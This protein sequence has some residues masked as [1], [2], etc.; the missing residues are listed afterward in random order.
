[1]HKSEPQTYSTLISRANKEYE[2]KAG[3][4]ETH[5]STSSLIIKIWN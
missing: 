4:T 5:K 2:F 3:A 1:M